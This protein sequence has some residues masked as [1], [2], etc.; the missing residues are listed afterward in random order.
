MSTVFI[1]RVKG[2]TK[3]GVAEEHHG[4]V[5]EK[6]R[7]NAIFLLGMIMERL[8]QMQKNVCVCFLNFVKAFDKFQHE[9]L[10]EILERLDVDEKELEMVRKSA[11][12]EKGCY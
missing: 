2:I 1:N 4:Y 7:R 9:Q 12:R 10:M 3:G 5:E 11:L 6:D 8:L